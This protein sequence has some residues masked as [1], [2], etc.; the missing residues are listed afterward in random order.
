MSSARQ[1]DTSAIIVSAIHKVNCG[2]PPSIET[3]NISWR[4]T[5]SGHDEPL[6]REP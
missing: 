3:P 5:A 2:F 6:A 1:Y 4:A